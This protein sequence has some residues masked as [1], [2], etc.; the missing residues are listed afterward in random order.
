VELAGGL[1]ELVHDI[2]AEDFPEID[3]ERV[4]VIV[5]E[6]LDH[7][8]DPFGE[9]S[10][11]YAKRALEA[12]GIEVR[13][14]SMLEGVDEAGVTLAGG[15]RIEARTI[16][17]T[18]GVRPQP[19]AEELGLEL[20]DGGRIV[21]DDDLSVPG[22]PNVFAIGD[23]AGATDEDGEPYP[24]LA[25][26]AIQQG[27]HVVRQIALRRAGRPTERFAYL[28]KGT[29]AKLGRGDAVAELPHGRALHGAPAWAAWLFVHLLYLVGF[30]NRATVLMNWAYSYLGTDRAARLIVRGEQRP[31]RTPGEE[32]DRAA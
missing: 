17:W 3:L 11:T 5:V 26:V 25:P 24:Q 29:M 20:T 9:D 7:V 13:V 18:A 19:L 16:I 10:R 4:R 22:H 31:R 23:I 21:V 8:L 28:D 32:A 1:A 12:R 27:E 6:A 2:L 14:G 30:R 15:E